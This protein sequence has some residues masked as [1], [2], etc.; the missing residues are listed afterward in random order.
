M[1]FREHNW[2]WFLIPLAL[3]VGATCCEMSVLATGMARGDMIGSPPSF[4]AEGQQSIRWLQRD[5][6]VAFAGVI[7]F[8]GLSSLCLGT[9]LHRVFEHRAFEAYFAGFAV[10]PLASAVL[11]ALILYLGSHH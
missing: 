11:L 7:V 2:I 6:K 3:V 1:A 4:T 8:L 5:G 9:V 10:C